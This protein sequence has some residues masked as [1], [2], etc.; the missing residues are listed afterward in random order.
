MYDG[1][2]YVCGDVDDVP[3][4]DVNVTYVYD[5]VSY[6]CGDVAG[7]ADFADVP[8]AAAKRSGSRDPKDR[9]VLQQERVLP[10]R[11]LPPQRGVR[12][13]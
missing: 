5:D 9:Q 12:E 1:A 7:V 4:D 2:T 3:Y 8:G 13:N 6:V 10:G 11:Y